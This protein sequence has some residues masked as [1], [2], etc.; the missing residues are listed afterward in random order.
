[1]FHRQDYFVRK[2]MRDDIYAMQQLLLQPSL[3]FNGRH[4]VMLADASA[5]ISMVWC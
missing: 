4:R 5:V 3:A 2:E 1:M